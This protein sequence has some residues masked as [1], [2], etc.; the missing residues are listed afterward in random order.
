MRVTKLLWI[1]MCFLLAAPA[2]WS[3]ATTTTSGPR[4]PGYLEPQTGAFQR[5]PQAAAEDIEAP[6]AAT[7]GGTVTVTRNVTLKTTPLTH[8]TCSAAV[9]ALDRTTSRV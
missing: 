9:S 6:A 7:I 5:V 3:Q 2:V 1:A 4:I 8:L